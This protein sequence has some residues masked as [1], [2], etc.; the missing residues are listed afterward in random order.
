MPT[1]QDF[2]VHPAA[3]LRNAIDA[4]RAGTADPGQ[5]AMLAD[6]AATLL[7]DPTTVTKYVVWFAWPDGSGRWQPGWEHYDDSGLANGAARLKLAS[8]SSYSSVTVSGP[9]SITLP[10]ANTGP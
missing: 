9:H 3:D 2:A 4:A 8:P 6:T 10:G 5:L 1:F 7:P